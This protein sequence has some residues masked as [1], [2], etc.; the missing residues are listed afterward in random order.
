MHCFVNKYTGHPPLV[1]ISMNWFALIGEVRW[2]EYVICL[3]V[4]QF[5]FLTIFCAAFPLAPL[6]ALLN[7]IIEIR[8][9]ASKFITQ[10]RRPIAERAATIGEDCI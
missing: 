5:G 10:L 8:V 1:F 7:N 4:L 2:R 6:F 3:A 9:D